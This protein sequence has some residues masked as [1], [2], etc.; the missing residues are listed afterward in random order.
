MADHAIT[1]T[2]PTGTYEP[3]RKRAEQEHVSVEEAAL[4]AIQSALA[5]DASSTKDRA[6]MLAALEALDTATLWQLVRRGAETDEVLLLS[7]LNERRQQHGPNAAEESLVQFLIGQHDRA[8]LLRAKA[9]ALLRQR[10]EDVQ[11][12]VGYR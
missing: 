2:V 11:A 7:A 4:A 8:V 5:T 9:I 3:F 10:G 6:S 12:A 1:V